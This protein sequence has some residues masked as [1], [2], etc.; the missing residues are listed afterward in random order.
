MVHDA[1]YPF[2]KGGAEKRLYEISRRL[3]KRHDVHVYGMKWW[4]GKNV[5]RRDGVTIHG[6]CEGE[7]Y[8]GG[9]RS[10]ATALRFSNSV[11][12][13]LAKERFD[14]IDC[15]QAPY[16]HCFSAK[17]VAKGAKLIFTWHEVWSG[18]P[19]AYWGQYLGKAGFIGKV[20]ERTVLKLP[21]TVIAVSDK[22]RRELIGIGVDRRNIALI[23]NGVDI[24]RIKKIAPH[25][26]KTD[27]LFAGRLVKD[28]N[29]DVLLRAVKSVREKI[30][31]VVCEII[32]MGPEAENLKRL[33]EELNLA[34][35]VRF[36]G[37]LK[38][39]SDVYA[40][41]KSSKVFAFPSTREG[42]GIVVLEANACG[43]PVIA[44]KH[45]MNAA[46][47][48][49]SNG[50]N[51]FVVRFSEKEMADKITFLLKNKRARRA[52]GANAS[53]LSEEYDWNNVAIQTEAAYLTALAGV[54]QA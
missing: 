47:D 25:R 1:I 36:L 54:L 46:A 27:I 34:G 40:H 11:L 28:K 3:A 9:K 6:V 15:Y 37:F 38:T 20:V 12:R 42:F 16:I 30:P 14:V 31:K 19:N 26:K 29:V 24:D 4:K 41:M 44:V 53:K 21:D 35:N 52:M 43:L 22:T 13:E 32:G 18:G 50:K 2:V 8:S 17:A 49:I 33:A 51:G 39:D 48:L 7:L 45:E 10:I 23:P 5:I